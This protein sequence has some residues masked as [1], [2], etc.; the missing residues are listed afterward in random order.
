MSAERK[1]ACRTSG[2]GYRVEGAGSDVDVVN[3]YLRSL[4]LRGLSAKTVRAY[5]MGLVVLLRWLDLHRL[6]STELTEALL[7]EFVAAQRDA[8]AKP[9]SI[10]RRLTTARLFFRFATGEELPRGKG[11]SAPTPY[12][13]GRRRDR[14]LGVH[15]V[16]VR[17]RLSLRVKVPRTLVEPLPHETVRAFLDRLHRHRD[18]AIVYLMLLCGLRSNEVLLLLLEDFSFEERK[19]R[20]KGKGAKERAMPVPPVL[21]DLLRRYLDVERPDHCASS[22]LFVVLQGKARG[23]PMTADG[24]RSLFRHRRKDAELSRANAHRFR[25]TFGSDMARAGVRLPIL[26]RMMGHAHPETTLQYVNLSMSDVIAEYRRA[27]ARIHRRY[28]KH[29]P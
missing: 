18:L 20:V 23:E 21:A 25:H 27:S 4:E 10:N 9:R 3:A 6:G 19:L 16:A 12:F 8:N 17:R 5:A 11:V 1:R 7:L 26:Q 13:R 2:G 22:H 24:L 14:I 28:G 15:N 29:R